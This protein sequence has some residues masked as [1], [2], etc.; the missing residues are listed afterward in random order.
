M[1]SIRGRLLNS[2]QPMRD[3][4][5][6]LPKWSL[7]FLL[8]AGTSSRGSCAGTSAHLTRYRK[9]SDRLSGGKLGGS[10]AT[11]CPRGGRVHTGRDAIVGVNSKSRIRTREQTS[12]NGHRILLSRAS[13]LHYRDDR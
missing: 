12:S 3:C 10:A 11:V 4:S 1:G 6:S 2:V 13:G 9:K 5:S 7:L 8:K